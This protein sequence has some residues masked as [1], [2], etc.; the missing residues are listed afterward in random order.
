[1]T[2]KNKIVENKSAWFS[3]L[4]ETLF[5]LLMSLCLAGVEVEIEC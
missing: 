5:R 3:T 4:Y 1:M 2:N